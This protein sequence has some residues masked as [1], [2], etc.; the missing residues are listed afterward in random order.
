MRRR[1]AAVGPRSRRRS[2]CQGRALAGKSSLKARLRRSV[3]HLQ[4]GLA[5]P[6]PPAPCPRPAAWARVARLRA[7]L[8]RVAAGR[9][10]PLALS[11]RVPLRVPAWPRWAALDQ[12]LPGPVPVWVRVPALRLS[13]PVL[14]RRLRARRRH[15]PQAARVRQAV[16]GASR[17]RQGWGFPGRFR[18][19][20]RSLAGPREDQPRAGHR[21]VAA[22][23]QAPDLGRRQQVQGDRRLRPGH[24]RQA[25]QP[26]WRMDRPALLRVR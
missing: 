11:G 1:C 10:R 25:P 5:R 12:G 2:C 16:Q 20:V 26:R 14:L 22:Q 19:Q 8:L 24:R 9:A 15:L 23:V 4:E 21:R 13:V 7:A 3:R 18:R 17:L 6:R